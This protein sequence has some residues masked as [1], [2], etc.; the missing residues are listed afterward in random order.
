MLKTATPRACPW[1]QPTSLRSTNLKALSIKSPT[2]AAKLRMAR[3]LTRVI[4]ARPIER[5]LKVVASW[6]SFNTR[7]VATLR[8]RPGTRLQHAGS[9]SQIHGGAKLRHDEAALSLEP[10]PLLWPAQGGDPNGVGSIRYEFA[11]CA[12]QSRKLAS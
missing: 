8:Y 7:P 9:Q 10:R 6:T 2:F 12:F 5:C 11:Q 4:T 1:Y 3:W